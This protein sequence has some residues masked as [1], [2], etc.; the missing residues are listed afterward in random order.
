MLTASTLNRS[1][2]D[3]RIETAGF[4]VAGSRLLQHGACRAVFMAWCRHLCRCA[5]PP[6]LAA[7]RSSC[8]ENEKSTRL[9][10]HA[11]KR[12]VVTFSRLCTIVRLTPR[13]LQYVVHNALQSTTDNS[14]SV[15]VWI[16][17][18][19][20]CSTYTTPDILRYTNYRSTSSIPCARAWQ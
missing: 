5:C 19:K 1:T 11:I 3:D 18:T 9:A 15:Y 13:R 12:E 7:R 20:G 4:C 10:A 14:H 17:R 16:H 8:I 6:S 2:T